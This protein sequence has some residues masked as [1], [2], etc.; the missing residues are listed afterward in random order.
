VSELTAQTAAPKLDRDA[1]LIL[2]EI[3]AAAWPAAFSKNMD[4]WV[5]R[6]SGGI[7][8]R[9][10]PVA[11]FTVDGAMPDLGERL[12]TIE[13]AYRAKGTPPR[14]QVSPAAAP[15]GLD[16]VLAQRGYEIEAPVYL[17][18]RAA[19]GNDALPPAGVNLALEAGTA[20]WDLYRKG[21]GRDARAIVAG[22]RERP[23][24]AEIPRE[25]GSPIAI[26]L[27]VEGGDFLGIFSMYTAPEARGRG[28]GC[29][30]IEAFAAH[31]IENGRSTLYLQVERKNVAAI[32]LYE[33]LGFEIAYGYHY[34]TLWTET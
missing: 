11:P 1:I 8:R 4:G 28:H 33:R 31:A 17:M 6:H 15:D 29:A 34:R 22:S 3:A 10:D 9:A 30:I 12:E 26:G 7:S 5:L 13:A 14:F 21:F 32:R 16:D 23:A 18:I 19:S 27:A 24:F 25:N 2:D 20:W